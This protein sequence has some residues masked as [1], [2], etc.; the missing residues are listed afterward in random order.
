MSIQLF[1]PYYRKDEVLKEIEECLDLGWTGL[2]FKTNKFEEEF[3]KYADIPYAH[4]VASNTAGLQIAI[5]ILKD[6]NKWKN[7]D[8]I[9]T[10]PLTFVSSNHSIVYNNLQPVFADVDDSLCLDL[11]SIKSKVTKKT[12]AI[13]FVGI[14]GNIGQYNEIRDFCKENGLKLILDAL[15]KDLEEGQHYFNLP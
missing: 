2:G 14:G 6:A 7:G 11:E 10:T 3:T 8:E 9:I 4:Y 1:R 5:K 15:Y 13:L 12:K